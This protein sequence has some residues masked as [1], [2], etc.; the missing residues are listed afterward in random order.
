MLSDFRVCERARLG[1][2]G[3]DLVNKMRGAMIPS[4]NAY[5]VVL[6]PTD[7]AKTQYEYP[8]AQK[9]CSADEMM[10]T[11]NVCFLPGL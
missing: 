4:V 1:S 2:S 10:V 7:A 11:T 3:K 9:P 8:S 5:N 6:F